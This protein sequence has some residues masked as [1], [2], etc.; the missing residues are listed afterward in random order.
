MMGMHDVGVRKAAH[1]SGADRMGR[2]ASRMQATAKYHHLE[3]MPLSPTGR[4]TSERHEAA[5]HFAGDRPC[6]LEGIPLASAE[7]PTDTEGGRR[8]VGNSHA[9]SVSDH[10]R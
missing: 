10:A 8:H 7:Q 2:M 5:R 9:T 1:E 4:L 6:E 3:P